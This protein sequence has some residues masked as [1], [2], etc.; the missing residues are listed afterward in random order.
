MRFP[1]IVL[2]AVEEVEEELAEEAR[3]IWFYLDTANDWIK[4]LNF[5]VTIRNPW[6]WLF[7]IV[8]L[9]VSLFRGWKPLMIGYVVSIV[10]W[11]IVH[12]TVLK[13]KAS[14]AQSTSSVMV[15]A[16]LTVGVAGIAIYFLLIRE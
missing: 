6:F 11:G 5:E 2:A 15:F 3:D 1:G 14:A 8:L 7:S 4:N 12:H 10:L 13:D 9:V 16:A